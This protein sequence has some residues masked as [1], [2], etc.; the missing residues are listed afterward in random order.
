MVLKDVLYR[1][2]GIEGNVATVGLIPDNAVYRAHFPGMP[3]TPG[4]CIIGM[5]R[6][7][8]EVMAGRQLKLKVAKDV[9]FTNLLTP[10]SDAPVTVEY[11]T[12]NETEEGLSAVATVSREGVKIAK[13]S[14]VFD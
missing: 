14:L 6:E 3:I 1:V 12:F 7:L 4:V 11:T 10:D 8:A 13:L 2:I 9:K 5:C